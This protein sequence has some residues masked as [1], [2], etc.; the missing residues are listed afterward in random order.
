MIWGL[1]KKIYPFADSR[2]DTTYIFINII[3]LIYGS[4]AGNLG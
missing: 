3:N 4:S 1:F 2:I